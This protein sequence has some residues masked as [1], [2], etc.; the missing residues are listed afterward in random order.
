MCTGSRGP[1]GCEPQILNINLPSPG[2]TT[3]FQGFR[4]TLESHTRAVG[5]EAIGQALLFLRKEGL[6]PE[7][8]HTGHQHTK[9]GRG[10]GEER[11]KEGG[12]L[13]QYLELRLERNRKNKRHCPR[14]DI[15]V[16][17]DNKDVKEGLQTW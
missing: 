16:E 14:A 4:E 5:T 9:G 10:N 7:S 15:H 3:K 2:W 11:E 8:L 6:W 17:L 13:L 1:W 12:G